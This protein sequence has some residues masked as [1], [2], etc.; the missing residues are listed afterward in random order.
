MRVHY[1]L[2]QTWRTLTSK[3]Q[4]SDLLEI[5]SVLS[6]GL[7]SLFIQMHPSEQAHSIAVYK[8]L[9]SQGIQNKDLLTA[10]LLHDVGKNRHPI[11]LW[12]RITIVLG[13]T[14][15][16][17]KAKL[18]SEGKPEGLKRPFVVAHRHAEWGADLA[19]QAGASKLTADLI[20]R[21]QDSIQNNKGAITSD[22]MNSS[23]R[24]FTETELLFLL[25]RSDNLY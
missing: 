23:N 10:A 11:K 2:F 18:W 13:E 21:H 3:P 24:D 8:N 5:K 25:Q 15:L 22:Q 20:R 4:S 19:A 6:P 1:R 12:E 16:P 9:L 17:E 7:Y 14:F